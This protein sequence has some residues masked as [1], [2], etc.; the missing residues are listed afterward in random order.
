MRIGMLALI[1]VFSLAACD[2]GSG[3]STPP[4]QEDIVEGLADLGGPDA[5]PLEDL[6]APPEDTT[7]APDTAAMDAAGVDTAAP[8]DTG[9][10]DVPAADVP[11]WDGPTPV[12]KIQ[13]GAEVIPQ[14]KLH[15]I[16]SQSVSPGSSITAYQ[17]SVV[18]PL[19][20]QS[21]FLPSATA[22]DPTFEVNVA[23]TYVFSL[24]VWDDLGAKSQQPAMMTV[25]V[26]PNE[27]I[28][29]ELLWHNPTDPDETDEGP[30][31]GADLDLHF[32]HPLA[33]QPGEPD[34]DGDGEPDG[35]FNQPFDC[36]WFNGFPDWGSLDPLT[37]DDPGLDRD[38]TDGAGPENINLNIP[39][40]LT[41]RVGVHYWSDHN[42]GAALAIVLVYING[43]LVW[44]S[45]VTEL[46]QLDLWEVVDITWT[47]DPAEPALL[48]TADAEIIPNYKHP[49]FYYE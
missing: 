42:F 30:E 40:A 26:T 14:T 3:S 28:H 8:Q 29:V 48:S 46:T 18:Q 1:L 36:F 9:G 15:L 16:G 4:R 23:G 47:G 7:V 35:W 25:D 45:Q 2:G 19:G 6:R 39:E 17:W 43:A 41:Y 5:E 27:A 22:P 33:V 49:L 13:E 20:S 38:D 34:V 10:E 21:V 44:E 24:D 11:P 32:L 31:A 37:D 12:V